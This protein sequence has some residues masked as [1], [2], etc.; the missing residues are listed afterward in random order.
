M[1]KYESFLAPAMESFVAFRKASGRWN[2]CDRQNLHLFDRHCE[3]MFPWVLEL[4]QEMVDSW[5][6][7][8]DS[9]LS[10]T[11]RGRI[12][13]IFHFVNYLKERN[14]TG[15]N[16]PTIPVKMPR[17]YI[18]H[19]FTD[20]ELANFF[21]ACDNL[22]ATPRKRDVLLRRITVPVFFRLL[23]SSGIRLNEARWLRA[24]DVNLENGVLNVRHSK[25]SSQHFVVLHDTMMVLMNRYDSTMRVLYPERE[26]FFSSARGFCLSSQWV[27]VN[28]RK[29]WAIHNT[30]HAVAYD[31]RHNYAIE[32]INQ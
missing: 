26:Y 24:D 23:Y 6:R 4:T 2:D 17:T 18:P 12:Y 13:V 11:H 21:R 3:V 14:L 7:K 29:L 10:N 25:G 32:N 20:D 27:V 28:F 5:C 19:A 30:A 15:I 9:E 1:Q 22:P 16:A 31:L 8:R